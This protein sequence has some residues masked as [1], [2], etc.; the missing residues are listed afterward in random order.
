MSLTFDINTV[1][2]ILNF[3]GLV[4]HYASHQSAAGLRFTKCVSGCDI[5]LQAGSGLISSPA[6]GLQDYNHDLDCSWL[7]QDP[8]GRGLTLVFESF[9]TEPELDYVEV[10][11]SLTRT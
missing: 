2:I 1:N 9:N 4:H 5:D 3:V 11:C 7:I 6:Y 10:N 8:D